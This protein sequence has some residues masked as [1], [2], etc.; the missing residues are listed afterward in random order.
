[1]KKILIV[2]ITLAMVFA[3]TTVVTARP[4]GVNVEKG[5]SI[6]LEKPDTDADPFVITANFGISDKLLL[7]VGYITE[8]EW[9]RW[10]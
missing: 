7:S 2:L 9:V 3:L 1:L 5:Y 8:D 4:L 10:F 6:S